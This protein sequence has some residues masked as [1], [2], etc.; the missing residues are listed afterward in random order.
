MN[1]RRVLQAAGLDRRCN[2]TG[3]DDE[4]TGEDDERTGEDEDGPSEDRAGADERAEP[5]RTGASTDDGASTRSPA[6][7]RPDGGV[8][9]NSGREPPSAAKRSRL[10]TVSDRLGVDHEKVVAILVFLVPGMTLFAIFSIGPIAYSAVGSFFSWDAF[11]MESFIGWD[12]WVETFRDPLIIN[13]D[14]LREFRFPMGALPQNLL[15][16]VIHV[17]LSTLF[18]LGLALLFADLK[19]RRILRSMVF[20]GFTTPTIIIG[21]VMLFVYDPQAG[22]FNELLRVV[23]L[24]GQVRN[25]TQE[26]QIAIYALIAGGVWVQ[27]GF[28]M[29]LYSSALAAVDPSLIESAKID[30]AGRVRRF[31]DIIWPQVKPVTAV[32]VIM[33]IIWVLRMF[34]IVYAAGGTSGGPNHVYSVLGIEVYRAAF[35]PPLEYG[36]AMVIAL[37]E[38]LIVA[39]LALYIARMR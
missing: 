35:E 3:E 1:L 12:N 4:R 22:I 38:L 39:P 28:S 19:G 13:W 9:D 15:W 20:L 10:R 31:V 37:I 36:H 29:L 21:I 8:A 16:V 26:P 25:W 7:P 18:G 23:G 34:D 30:G 11:T 32:V 14:N 6:G 17:P 5:T 33:G 2:R 27:T 24:E